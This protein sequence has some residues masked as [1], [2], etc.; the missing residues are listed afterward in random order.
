MPLETLKPCPRPGSRIS[1]RASRDVCS[2]SD[3]RREEKPAQSYGLDGPCIALVGAG[4]EWLEPLLSRQTYAGS[5]T[6]P[7]K[8]MSDIPEAYRAKAAGGV[9]IL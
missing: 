3:R 7:A 4:G 2:V 1:Y 5:V 8:V 6:S 9:W